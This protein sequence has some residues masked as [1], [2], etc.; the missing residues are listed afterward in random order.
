MTVDPARIMKI[1][2]DLETATLRINPLI[3]RA[4]SAFSKIG[5]GFPAS[6]L[7]E[8]VPPRRGKKGP[9]YLH[10]L[11][12]RRHG[13]SWRLF[14][15]SCPEDMSKT[16]TFSLLETSSRRLRL[17]ALKALP[18]LEAALFPNSGGRSASPVSARPRRS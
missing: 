5:P 4:E 18:E 13:T 3:Q 6:V 15:E 17:L 11:W 7:L 16:P 12:L 2:E 8:R 14:V 10:K 9:H 1:R